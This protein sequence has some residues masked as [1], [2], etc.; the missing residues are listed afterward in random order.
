MAVQGQIVMSFT[1]PGFLIEDWREHDE[2]RRLKSMAAKDHNSRRVA[3]Q[4]K[5]DLSSRPNST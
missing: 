1:P 4:V 3:Q 5:S 2:V